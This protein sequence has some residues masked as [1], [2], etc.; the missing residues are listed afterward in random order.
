MATI[1]QSA[2]ILVLEQVY[3]IHQFKYKRT[4]FVCNQTAILS[5]HKMKKKDCYIIPWKENHHKPV[6]NCCQGPPEKR[7]FH[8]ARKQTTL[9]NQCSRCLAA[10][11]IS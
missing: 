11:L 9:T 5:Y 4:V 7:P 8:P 6:Y 10:L 3:K 1:L 2:L